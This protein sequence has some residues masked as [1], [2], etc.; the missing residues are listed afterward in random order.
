M[1]DKLDGAIEDIL[2]LHTEYLRLRNFVDLL[3]K[4]MRGQISID[5]LEGEWNKMKGGE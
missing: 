2:T 1:P 5:W 4:C 3:L